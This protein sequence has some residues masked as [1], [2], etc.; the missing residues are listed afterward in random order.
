MGAG[1]PAD[2]AAD[3]VRAGRRTG[4]GGHSPDRLAGQRGL[5]QRRQHSRQHRQQRDQLDRR[6]APLIRDAP[7][8]GTIARNLSR[9][10][11][12]M[13]RK[14]ADFVTRPEIRPMAAVTST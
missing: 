9:D 5:P 1:G 14:G 13:L 8:A 10:Y 12:Y 11:A 7:H 2:V 6:L 4:R 3:G